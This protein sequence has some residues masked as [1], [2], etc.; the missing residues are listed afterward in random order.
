[1]L[2]FI[3]QANY[4]NVLFLLVQVCGLSELLNQNCVLKHYD[5]SAISTTNTNTKVNNSPPHLAQKH[6][7]HVVISDSLKSIQY[8]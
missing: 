8:I 3:E 4:L 7:A 2:S 6:F 1:M 5:T